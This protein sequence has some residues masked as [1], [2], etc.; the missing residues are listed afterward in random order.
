MLIEGIDWYLIGDV[1]NLYFSC[2]LVIFFF[3][4]LGCIEN[5]IKLFGRLD[6]IYISKFDLYCNWIFL[7][8]G[9]I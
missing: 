3:M 8:I 2:L 9:I 5:V 1:I 6:V 4:N 7:Y